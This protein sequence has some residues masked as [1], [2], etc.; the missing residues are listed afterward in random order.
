[1]AVDF[2]KEEVELLAV[3]AWWIWKHRNEVKFGS[4]GVC[5]AQIV[6]KAQERINEFALAH[7]SDASVP[8]SSSPINNQVGPKLNHPN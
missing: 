8:S 1:M 5:G 7:L 4:G 2:S 3:I 6:T